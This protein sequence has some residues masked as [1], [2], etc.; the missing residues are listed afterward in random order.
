MAVSFKHERYIRIRLAD[1]SLYTFTSVNDAKTRIALKDCINLHSP[2]LTYALAD[3]NQTMVM[4]VEHES[5]ANQVSWKAAWDAEWG[6]SS[7][8]WSGN[9]STQ[10][11]EH[12]KTKWLHADGTVSSTANLL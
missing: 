9:N 3:S 2:I 5:D 7:W 10:T 8:P 11:V 12:F 6:Q 1:S 4:T